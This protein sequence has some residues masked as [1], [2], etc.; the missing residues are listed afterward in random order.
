[1]SMP[2]T[3]LRGLRSVAREVLIKPTRNATEES[4]RSAKMHHVARLIPTPDPTHIS[5]T[6]KTLSAGP[7]N[8]RASR[9]NERAAT[10]SS[11]HTSA[12]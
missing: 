12:A 9:G 7:M 3:A 8:A 4:A 5:A 10:P 11:K 6:A 2:A 1:M